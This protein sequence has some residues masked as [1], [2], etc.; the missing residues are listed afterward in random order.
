L[1]TTLLNVDRGK[2]Y[3]IEKFKLHGTVRVTFK[4]EGNFTILPK[5]FRKSDPE[6][7]V[8]DYLIRTAYS[9]GVVKASERKTLFTQ[10]TKA[11]PPLSFP[12]S[13]AID[14]AEKWKKNS[15][16]I[17]KITSFHP[18]FLYGF[19]HEQIEEELEE[20]KSK[21]ENEVGCDPEVYQVV[22]VASKMLGEMSKESTG[23]HNPSRDKEEV[24]IDAYG[25][26]EEARKKAHL[27]EGHAG[28]LLTGTKIAKEQF[29][30]VF[31]TNQA[32][33]AFYFAYAIYDE[34][35]FRNAHVLLLEEKG[36]YAIPDSRRRFGENLSQMRS[37]EG[38]QE[39]TWLF[40]KEGVDDGSDFLKQ[41]VDVLN[42]FAEFMKHDQRCFKKVTR[43][44]EKNRLE[45]MFFRT[46][47]SDLAEIYVTHGNNPTMSQECRNDHPWLNNMV[48]HH[49]QKHPVNLLLEYIMLCIDHQQIRVA[50]SH[51]YNSTKKISTLYAGMTT[52][53]VPFPEGKRPKTRDIR[54]LYQLV[55]A[56]KDKT[57]V[58]DDW[59]TLPVVANVILLGMRNPFIKEGQEEERI[60]WVPTLPPIDTLD[61]KKVELWKIQKK[62]ARKRGKAKNEE[63]EEKEKPTTSEESEDDAG[64]QTNTTKS[65]TKKMA[66]KKK[67]NKEIKKR[68]SSEQTQKRRQAQQQDEDSQEDSDEEIHVQDEKD[69][70][71]DL[72]DGSEESIRGDVKS[73]KKREK[74]KSRKVDED[75]ANSV[76]EGTYEDEN[77]EEEEDD[78][79]EKKGKDE[80]EAVEKVDDE[81]KEATERA[82]AGYHDNLV[83]GCN[84]ALKSIKLG[85]RELHD[86]EGY[87]YT[88]ILE[89]VRNMGLT[90]A[91]TAA[92]Q[93]HLVEQELSLDF[94]EENG[95][96]DIS[97]VCQGLQQ[98]VFGKKRAQGGQGGAYYAEDGPTEEGSYSLFSKLVERIQLNLRGLHWGLRKAEKQQ[99]NGIWKIRKSETQAKKSVPLK[100]NKQFCLIWSD[101]KA[102]ANSNDARKK[103]NLVQVERVTGANNN[104]QPNSNEAESEAESEKN[105]TQEVE[106]ETMKKNNKKRKQETETDATPPKTRRPRK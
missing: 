59:L 5:D 31:N 62:V 103:T 64:N 17:F 104:D 95:D 57:E 15:N 13:E 61:N 1:E 7:Y 50:P 44:E 12:K 25:S 10:L 60:E 79:E 33:I 63:N 68:K 65:K 34:E 30:R 14:H 51:L 90:I 102:E 69:C 53:G 4:K 38:Y 6:K 81:K 8:A 52:P 9:T 21:G 78:R 32:C 56:K 86:D 70:N 89:S 96:V 85:R 18:S 97:E 27:L 20:I 46:L 36:G 82:L 19:Y 40:K 76:D 91:I 42:R 74:K 39:E 16:N 98:I 2:F 58:M 100:D 94:Q 84:S 80:E 55:R 77:E 105:L 67:Q 22:M 29:R 73:K 26:M 99:E 66:A 28:S 35:S 48:K 101:E 54:Y 11:E 71:D 43:V 23:Q 49:R 88:Q 41:V 83:H 37:Q 106:T 92:L 24:Y 3:L 47:A 87:H 45:P 93:Q 75:G 72:N